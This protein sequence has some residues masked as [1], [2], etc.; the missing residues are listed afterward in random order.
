MVNGSLTQYRNSSPVYKVSQ[1]EGVRLSKVEADSIFERLGF[2]TG[3]LIEK[4]NGQQIDTP[5][6]RMSFVLFEA[7]TPGQDVRVKLYR[8]G[9][10][11]TLTFRLK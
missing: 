7:L 6:K 5:Q 1:W 2:R 8:N 4:V 9:S 10:K 11:K 3:D